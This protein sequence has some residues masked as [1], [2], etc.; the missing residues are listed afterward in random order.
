[1]HTTCDMTTTRCVSNLW[2]E[3]ND[4][5]LTH[6]NIRTH[7]RPTNNIGLIPAQFD[8]VWCCVRFGWRAFK[9]FM[10]PNRS[11][12]NVRRV[13]DD[14]SRLARR[15]RC[16]YLTSSVFMRSVRKRNRWRRRR[17][18]IANVFARASIWC[19]PDSRHR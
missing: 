4:A 13:R 17:L 10:I 15:L 1:M 11:T 14:L 7:T 12:T 18:S 2:R 19:I 8:I 5:V 9:H 16:V 6:L 3:F